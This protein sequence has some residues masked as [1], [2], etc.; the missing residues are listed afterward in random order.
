[1]SEES[2][3]LARLAPVLPSRR[4]GSG[5]GMT[6]AGNTSD[7]IRVPSRNLFLALQPHP[8]FRVPGARK[9]HPAPV[10]ASVN[11]EQVPT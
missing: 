8:R 10:L 7:A 1:M 2:G 11:P 5:R 6:A 4:G 3:A 9:R